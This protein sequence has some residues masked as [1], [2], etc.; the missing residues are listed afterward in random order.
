MLEAV[1]ILIPTMR[2]WEAIQPQ[3]QAIEANTTRPH[4]I[5][6]SCQPLSSA[7]NR[8][9]CLNLAQTPIVIMLDDDIEGFT[10]GWEERLLAPLLA[11]P[12]LC[13]VSARLLNPNGKVQNTCMDN[14]ALTPDWLDVPVR[15]NAVVPSAAIAFRE[16]GLRFDE[17]YIGSG[18][19]DTDFCQQFARRA[20]DGPKGFVCA[21]TCPLIH[22]HEQKNQ[23]GNFWVTNSRYYANKWNV[24]V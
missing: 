18:W 23:Q 8:N 4:R 9:I 15:G 1:D 21:N 17:A 5:V 7:C 10:P 16:L 12:E 19:E 22:R 20:G 14:N 3:V 2:T 6:A 11:R 24:R 13:M